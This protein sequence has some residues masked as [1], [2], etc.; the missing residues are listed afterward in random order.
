[1]A[2]NAPVLIWVSDLSKGYV[3]FNNPWLTFVGRTLEQERGNG[4]AENVHPDD[5]DYCLRVY[6]SAFDAKREFKMQYRLRRHDGEWRWLLDHGVPRLEGDNRFVG[7]IGSCIDITEYKEALAAVRTAKNS[8][9]AFSTPPW[10]QS[11]RLTTDRKS[12]TSMGRR[13]RCSDV[14][15]RRRLANR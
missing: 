11:L 12:P 6:E 13:R 3:W 2:D 5:V 9:A 15:P 10:T 7:F 4:W 8:S 14:G 1:M